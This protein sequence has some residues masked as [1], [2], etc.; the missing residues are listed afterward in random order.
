MGSKFRYKQKGHAT[1]NR[2]VLCGSNLLHKL[3]TTWGV[4]F[5]SKRKRRSRSQGQKW[6]YKQKSLVARHTWYT[7]LISFASKVMGNVNCFKSMSISRSMSWGKIKMLVPTERSCLIHVLYKSPVS[8]NSTM[9]I[10]E[11]KDKW[12]EG[13]DDSYLYLNRFMLKRLPIYLPAQ[14]RLWGI[15]FYFSKKILNSMLK[16]LQ[17]YP[18]VFT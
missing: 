3:R 7:T 13:Q 1:R 15:N 17:N 10:F 14:F 4:F 6:R 12:T 5:F 8:F 16:L 9:C 18:P 2:H 11:Q